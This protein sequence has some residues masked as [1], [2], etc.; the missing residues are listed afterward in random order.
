[1][2]VFLLAFPVGYYFLIRHHRKHLPEMKDQIGTLWKDVDTKRPITRYYNIWFLARR[3]VYG[4]VCGFIGTWDG[5]LTVCSVVYMS[6]GYTVY[7]LQFSPHQSSFDNR[8]ELISESLLLY[9]FYGV[10]VCVVENDPERRHQI[11]W[12]CIGI[13][14][15]LTAIKV[16]ILIEDGIR[17][18]IAE[19][20]SY[21]A[22]RK[23]LE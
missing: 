17:Y 9:G 7:C 18:C 12:V 5:G 11:G 19:Y 10:M 3:F 6:I 2:I 16:Y 8:I 14:T 1:M 22:K 15:L 23:R 4:A 20:K 21:F 13:I